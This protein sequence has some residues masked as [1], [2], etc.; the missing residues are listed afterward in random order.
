MKRIFVLLATIST[1][2]AVALTH[3]NCPEWACQTCTA[4]DGQPSCHTCQY[5]LRTLLPKTDERAPARFTCKKLT[6]DQAN[7]AVPNCQVYQLNPKGETTLTKCNKCAYGYYQMEGSCYK[8]SIEF[9][10]LEQVIL[11]NGIAKNSCKMCMK[12]YKFNS[13]LSK[14][15]KIEATE[16]I[17]NCQF[18]ESSI[19]G[20][21]GCKV[22]DNGFYPTTDEYSNQI[23][24]KDL[25]SEFCAA[26]KMHQGENCE[27]CNN[28][29]GWMS[30]YA[31]V[32]DKT[33]QASK[34]C[35]YN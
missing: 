17:L 9:C 29:A 21:L 23:C 7:V 24:F 30:T 6:K 16:K 31:F 19:D 13:E 26:G 33:E 20:A 2:G 3:K 25:G 35:Y 8:N 22:C 15:T 27:K 5:S 1:L 10:I 4:V 11:K 12:G 34:F 28:F 18:Y 32:T 14:C